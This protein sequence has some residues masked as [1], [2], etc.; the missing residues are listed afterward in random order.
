MSREVNKL[1]SIIEEIAPKELMEEWDN[2][3]VQILTDKN[4]VKR[5]LVCLDVCDETVDE[6][7]E[8][9]CDFIVSHHPL[10]FSGIKRI[11]VG[12]AKGRYIIKLIKNDICVY[13]SHT[14]FDTAIGGNND[15]LAK[16]LGLN[17]VRV[18]EAEPIMRVGSLSK[19]MQMKEVCTLV[20]ERI[21]NNKGLSYSGELEREIKAVGICT[22]AGV[23]L[24]DAAIK[25]GC[26]LLI[27]C[28]V[29]YHDFQ[30][31]EE[32]GISIIDAGHFETEI[33]FCENMKDKLEKRLNNEAEVIAS[34]AQKNSLKRFFML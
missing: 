11:D 19:P 8:N 12:S 27:T 18:P 24:M 1:I 3:G 7:I 30:R 34:Q 15:Y 22:G 10:I 32:L 21:M 23:S 29:K 13:S 9:G 4:E 2:T 20:N 17:D 33:H 5:I 31:A 28:D 6:A 16:L 14:S 26:E 25:E